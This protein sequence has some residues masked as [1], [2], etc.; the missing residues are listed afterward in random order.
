[1]KDL[2]MKQKTSLRKFS[3]ELDV[4]YEADEVSTS[5]IPEN[6][7]VCGDVKGSSRQESPKEGILSDVTAQG[8]EKLTSQTA[9]TMNP[10]MKKPKRDLGRS[11]EKIS[12][13]RGRVRFNLSHERGK[14]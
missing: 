2:E 14:K 6:E 1:M 11:T 9:C 3:A 12:T 13:F 4:L 10:T 8:P 7:P 5:V